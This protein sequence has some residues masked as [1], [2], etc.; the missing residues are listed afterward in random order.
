MLDTPDSSA[1]ARGLEN[2]TKHVENARAFGLDPV[3]ALNRFPTDSDEEVKEVAERCRAL[4][5]AFCGVH[6]LRGWRGGRSRPRAFGGGGGGQG[7]RSKPLY[8]VDDRF[9]VKLD[10]LVKKVYGGDG[11]DF[12]DR[13]AADLVRVQQAGLAEGLICVAKTSLSLSDDA[14]KLGRPRGF[15]PSVHRVE[16]AAGAGFSIVYMGDVVTMPGLPKVPAAERI[17][18]TDDG[19]V[20]GVL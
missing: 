18:L 1:V 9:D 14:H 13:V 17:G 11:V 12:Q 16:P 20:T 8:S 2:L 6:G 10:A 15:R 3:V 4:R 19:V 5:V 7:G